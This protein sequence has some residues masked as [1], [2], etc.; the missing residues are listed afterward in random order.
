MRQTLIKERGLGELAC[1][2]AEDRLS[3]IDLRSGGVLM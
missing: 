1:F 2:H 3:K